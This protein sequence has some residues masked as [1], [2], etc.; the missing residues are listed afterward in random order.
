MMWPFM[1]VQNAF[2]PASHI[3][4]MNI[5]ELFFSPASIWT[6]IAVLG[7]WGNANANYLADIIFPPFGSPTVIFFGCC[8]FLEVA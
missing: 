2:N 4:P 6:S 7:S 5:N 8:L 3:L 1:C